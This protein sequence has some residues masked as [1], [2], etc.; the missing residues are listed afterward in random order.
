MS[1]AEELLHDKVTEMRMAELVG[2]T[3]KALQRKRVRK[4]ILPGVWMKIDGRIMYSKQ[5]YDEWIESLWT[6]HQGL[7]SS[8][9]PSEFASPGTRSGA[10]K[11]LPSLKPR[12]TSLL[13]RTYVLK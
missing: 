13:Q 7:S 12:K 8:G 9:L 1:A 5:R 10:A 3:A 6:R 2:T 11:R 4:I